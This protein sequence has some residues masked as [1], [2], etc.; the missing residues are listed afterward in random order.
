MTPRRVVALDGLRGLAILCVVVAHAAPANVPQL[1]PLGV[2]AFFVLSGY[3]I[4]SILVAEHDR[5]GSIDLRRFFRKRLVRLFPAMLVV[6]LAYL[7]TL[8]AAGNPTELDRGLVAAALGVTYLMD[9]AMSWR[10]DIPLS[11]TPLWSLA[12]E[13]HFY[14]VWPVVVAVVLSRA[15]ASRL[16]AL[17]W[18]VVRLSVPC[19]VLMAALQVH[20]ALNLYFLPTTW[21]GSLAVGAE[22]AMWA[23]TVASPSLET[24]SRRL[25]VTGSWTSLL[26]ALLTIVVTMLLARRGL[27]QVSVTAGLV[28]LLL[29]R[30][31]RL[32][33][34]W[35]ARLLSWSPLVAVGR[36]S[37]GIYLVN[38]PLME[39]MHVLGVP[40]PRL[41]GGIAALPVAWLLWRVVEGPA[42]RRWSGATPTGDPR[43]V[44]DDVSLSRT[45]SLGRPA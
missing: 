37:Y 12:V 3:L 16:R 38:L 23:R 2:V 9:V 10:P 7:L 27:L 45:P 20:T 33:H 24:A 35:L 43:T 34:T 8:A 28:G 30:V 26:V 6:V 19:L 15:D 25:G 4:T 14:L 18:V 39:L 21:V 13:E 5:T 1:G 42:Q 40:L 41:V 32:P 36:V 44:P 22:V 29:C 31:I 11:M 17:V